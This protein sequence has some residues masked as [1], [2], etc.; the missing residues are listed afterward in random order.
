[1]ADFMSEDELLDSF[2]SLHAAHELDDC[3]LLHDLDNPTPHDMTAYDMFQGPSC[4]NQLLTACPEAGCR[5]E[6]GKPLGGANN[7]GSRYAYKCLRCDCK[8]NQTR[9]SLLTPGDDRSIYR[10]A[11]VKNKTRSG[12]YRC[13]VCHNK[14]K[15]DLCLSGEAYCQCSRKSQRQP[16]SVRV[17]SPGEPR[18][19]GAKHVHA[20]FDMPLLAVSVSAQ[21]AQKVAPPADLLAQHANHMDSRLL[22]ANARVVTAVS[23]THLTLPTTPYV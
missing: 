6:P 9:P 19:E 7:D 10:R 21:S 15:P 23:Y 18:C 20:C 12:G 8:W 3:S 1:M 13:G 16:K 22:G 17:D 2:C 14:K 4:I 11:A 5:G